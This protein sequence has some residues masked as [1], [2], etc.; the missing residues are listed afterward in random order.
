MK[1]HFGTAPLLNKDF[2]ILGSFKNRLRED[3]VE[4]FAIFTDKLLSFVA[5]NLENLLEMFIIIE[6]PFK[7]FIGNRAY[8]YPL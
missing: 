3:L 7:N 8:Q 4:V 2:G 5:I 6:P 1:N